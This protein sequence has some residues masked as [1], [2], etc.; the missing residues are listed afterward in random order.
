MIVKTYNI[1]KY[2]ICDWGDG[3]ASI[4]DLEGFN[5]EADWVPEEGSPEY[6][7]EL[8]LNSKSTARQEGPNGKES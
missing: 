1:G 2:T 8:Y 5:H 3:F 4:E 6:L 7:V